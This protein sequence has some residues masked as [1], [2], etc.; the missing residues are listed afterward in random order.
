MKRQ[1]KAGGEIGANG[2]AYKGGQFIAEHPDTEKGRKRPTSRGKKQIAP[3]VWELPPSPAHFPLMDLAW[4][5]GSKWVEFGV[6]IQWDDEEAQRI[7]WNMW[8]SSLDA[9]H[10]MAQGFI[11]DRLEMIARY[12]RGERW[13]DTS[14]LPL[15]D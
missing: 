8:R 2:E 7:A 12:N 5:I 3:Y 4:G 6:T 15:A 11:V 9:K 1:A 13:L 14:G 10:D